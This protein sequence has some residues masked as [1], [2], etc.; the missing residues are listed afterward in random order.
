MG[1]RSLGPAIIVSTLALAACTDRDIPN[2]PNAQ[3]SVPSILNASTA[4]AA[5]PAGYLSAEEA[6]H[7]AKQAT[8]GPTP[9]LI[10]QIKRSQTIEAWLDAQMKL[11]ASTYSDIAA[12]GVPSNHCSGLPTQEFNICSRDNFSSLPVAMRFYSNAINNEDQLRQ[13]VAFSIS[14]IIVASDT[15]SPRTSGLAAY[16]QIFLDNAFGNFRD[17]LK[18]V[19]LNPY[20][21]I[22]LDTVDSNK[23]APNEN[24]A[25]ELM[26]LFSI[27]VVALNFDGTPQTDISGSPL[28]AYA[29][30]D[31]KEISRALTGWTVSRM[32]GYAITDST[33][34]DFS[35]PMNSIPSRFDSGAKSF[36]GKTVPAGASQEQNVDA[37]I[38]AVFYHPN[39]APF[40]AK[41]LIKQLTIANPTPAYVERVAAAFADNGAGQRGDM[42]AVVRAIYTDS[43]ARV[44]SQL[45]GKV[46]DPVL[47]ATSLAR[48][49]GF[50]SDGY[51]FTTRDL[52]M[53]Q[54][55]FRAPSVFGFYPDEYPL[56]Q[57]QGLSS[58]SSKL[59]NT[60]TVIARHNFVYDW[61]LAGD[62]TRSEYQAQS[63]IKNATGS[64]PSW[65]AWEAHGMDDA[66]TINRLNLL[67]LSGTMTK[68]Q[69]EAL[70][71]AMAA[72][73]NSDPAVQAR[74]RA[75]VALYLVASSPFFQVDR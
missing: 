28:P 61:T 30:N 33:H 66:K 57:G 54:Q 41:R 63:T 69:R 14:Q 15:K 5:A 21:G 39:T 47:L 8:F 29:T 10:D 56:S 71:S 1:I 49:I 17:I 44:V 52:A 70:L 7:F 4:I 26:Q 22:Y 11:K 67:M 43:E 68:G 12:N 9:E 3:G 53:G 48:T 19:T 55:P 40:I 34:G 6:A 50:K 18:A 25:R 2:A 60:A 16:N 62:A 59:M 42:K 13:R 23:T 31:V 35:R 45:P 58:P 20:M 46:K 74:K 75:Q 27:G 73:K 32:A 51:A 37:V 64:Q 38:D 24:Y 65:A 72:V 36:L